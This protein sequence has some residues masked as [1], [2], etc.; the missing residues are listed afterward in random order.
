LNPHR[1]LHQYLCQPGN[2]LIGHKNPFQ[3]NFMEN[4]D[5]SLSAI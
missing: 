3:K 1:I 5:F 4:E 2:S